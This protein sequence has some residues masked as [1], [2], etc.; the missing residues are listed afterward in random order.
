[1]AMTGF[2]GADEAGFELPVLSTHTPAYGVNYTATLT[3]A[4]AFLCIAAAAPEVTF[5]SPCECQGFHG[6]NRWGY[7][8][9]FVAC[10]F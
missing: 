9:R 4:V 2:H 3:I 10:A 7:Q 5:V 8:D 1:V 6:K